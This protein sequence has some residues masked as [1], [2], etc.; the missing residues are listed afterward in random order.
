MGRPPS[1]RWMRAALFMFG[2]GAAMFCAGLANTLAH[3]PHILSTVPFVSIPFLALAGFALAAVA[4]VKSKAEN[5]QLVAQALSKAR[6]EHDT[7]S[8]H[9]D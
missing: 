7:F 6:T 5:Q 1:L 3:G 9:D 4:S 2:I 8:R